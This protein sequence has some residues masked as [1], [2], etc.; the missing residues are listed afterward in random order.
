M[1]RGWRSRNTSTHSGQVEVE[2]LVVLLL[3]KVGSRVRN[4]EIVL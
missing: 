1:V 4:V 2:K 3:V